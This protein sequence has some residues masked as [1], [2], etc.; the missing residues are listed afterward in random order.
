MQA[1]HSIIFPY[2]IIKK[3]S[4]IMIVIGTYS[5]GLIGLQGKPSSPSI[6]FAFSVTTVKFI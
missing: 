4:Q 2:R 3:M 6:V 5:G 1:F